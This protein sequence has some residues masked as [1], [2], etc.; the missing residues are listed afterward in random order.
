MTTDKPSECC[1]KSMSIGFGFRECGRP[2]K[3]VVVGKID[4]QK[5]YRC[6]MHVK[7]YQTYL[8]EHYDV[9]PFTRKSPL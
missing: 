3:F 8:A 4:G 7:R 6:G 9:Q 1:Q 2:T 5:R